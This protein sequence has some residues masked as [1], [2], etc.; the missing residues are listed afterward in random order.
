MKGQFIL[1][2]SRSN[3][4]GKIMAVSP[5]TKPMFAIFEPITFPEAMSGFPPRAAFILTKSSGAEVAKETT[6][7]PITIL[8]NFNLKE[9]PTED[10]TK[11]S[12]P[13][14]RS[15]KPMAIST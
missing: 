13:I 7:K 10:F 2:K 15:T 8:D 11:N 5:N 12:P 3:S 6:V 4:I 1:K 14:T 9:S